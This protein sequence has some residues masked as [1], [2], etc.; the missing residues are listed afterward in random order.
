MSFDIEIN[1]SFYIFIMKQ[2]PTYF[3]EKVSTFYY[4][5]YEV[6]KNTENTYDITITNN[7]H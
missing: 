5:N 1:I 4:F 7:K 2:L 6:Y 3:D